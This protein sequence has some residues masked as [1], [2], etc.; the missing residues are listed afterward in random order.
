M[1]APTSASDALAI[2]K[3]RRRSELDLRALPS[4]T[5]RTTEAMA[6]SVLTLAE[7]NAKR[8]SSRAERRRFFEMSLGSLAEVGA[9]LDLAHAFGLIG[10]TELAATKSRLKLACAMIRALP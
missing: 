1:Q 6:S 2:S 10:S 9:C 4:A 5:L 8:R 3:N 7:G